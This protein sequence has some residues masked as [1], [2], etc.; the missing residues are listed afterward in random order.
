MPTPR[1][2]PGPAIAFSRADAAFSA[3]LRSAIAGAH[4]RGVV[5]QGMGPILFALE[6]HGVLTMSDLA[7]AACV[8]RSTMTGIAARMEKRGLVRLAPNPRDGR[9]TVVALTPK[10]KTTVPKMR[11]I[12]HHLDEA[13]SSAL[14]PREVETLTTYLERVASAFGTS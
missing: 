6:E 13:I 3:L 8:P 10:G 1:D 9:G 5:D 2:K 12:E 4:L 11:R 14:T 7:T